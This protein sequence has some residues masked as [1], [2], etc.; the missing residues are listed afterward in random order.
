MTIDPIVLVILQAIFSV[1]G[2][3]VSPIFEII[4]KPYDS[5]VRNMLGNLLGIVG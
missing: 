3:F 1:V 2:A 4:S 5:F